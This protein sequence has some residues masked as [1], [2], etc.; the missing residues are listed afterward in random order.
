MPVIFWLTIDMKPSY[1]GPEWRIADTGEL[2]TWTSNEHCVLLVGY[3]KECLYF[4][5]FWNNHGVVGYER[6]LVEQ[7]HREMF[8][9]AV[10]VEK[11]I[12]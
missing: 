8:S 5:D 4:N 1:K 7:R 3:D 6:T 11:H 9:M 10:V 12:Q 2:F